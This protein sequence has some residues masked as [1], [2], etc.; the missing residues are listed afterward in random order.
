[1][2]AALA[3]A[4]VERLVTTAA[5]P[6]PAADRD[7]FRAAKDSLGWSLPNMTHGCPVEPRQDRAE[8]RGDLRKESGVLR[9]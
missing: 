2:I 1:M 8:C 6:R 3:S 7:G 4:L 9:R 5:G